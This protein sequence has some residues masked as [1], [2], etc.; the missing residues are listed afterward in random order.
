MTIL[1]LAFVGFVTVVFLAVLGAQVV[2]D[3]LNEMLKKGRA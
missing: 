1:I 2:V 3:G